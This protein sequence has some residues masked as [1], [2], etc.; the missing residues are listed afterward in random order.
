MVVIV[1]LGLLVAVVA[2]NVLQNQDKAMV[3]KAQIDIAML[4]QALDMY[5]LDNTVYPT[6]AQGLESLLEPPAGGDS[7]NYRTGGYIK[8]LPEDPWGN[9]YHYQQPGQHGPFDLYSFGADGSAGGSGPAAD[10]TNW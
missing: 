7:V 2:P 6:T 5:K 1:I 10:I 8:R 4:E 3:S 9:A